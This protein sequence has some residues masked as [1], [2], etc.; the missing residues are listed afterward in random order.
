MLIIFIFRETNIILL[1][2]GL[3]KLDYVSKQ[4]EMLKTEITD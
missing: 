1:K 3:E 2:F 4:V